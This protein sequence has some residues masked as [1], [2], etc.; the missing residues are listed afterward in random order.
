MRRRRRG[1]ER[2]G[3]GGDPPE[4]RDLSAR[5]TEQIHMRSLIISIFSTPIKS[6]RM[7]G[8]LFLFRSVLFVFV[9][10]FFF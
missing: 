9:P 4:F 2:R 5:K 7:F 10:F 6:T 3:G 1:E 8:F